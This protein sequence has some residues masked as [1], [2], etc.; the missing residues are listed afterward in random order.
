MSE[1]AE[2]VFL[3]LNPPTKRKQTVT[4]P[5]YSR[6][7]HDYGVEYRKRISATETLSI[8]EKENGIFSGETDIRH[9]TNDRM[10]APDTSDPSYYLGTGQYSCT[11]DEFYKAF[12]SAME[13]LKRFS[14]L[15]L[16]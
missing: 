11:S 4:F 2:V 1:Q 16:T 15:Q 5:I 9:S 8:Y 3:V 6:H 12:D 10:G 13:K 7:N 14:G